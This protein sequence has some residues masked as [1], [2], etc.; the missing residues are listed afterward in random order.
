MR[1][2]PSAIKNLFEGRSILFG[3][4]EHHGDFVKENTVP[5]ERQ[6]SARNLNAL[7]LLARSRGDE[8]LIIICQLCGIGSLFEEMALKPRERTSRFAHPPQ[9]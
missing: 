9:A 1:R 7:T 4:P 5:R 6:H 8:H 3:R 2:D